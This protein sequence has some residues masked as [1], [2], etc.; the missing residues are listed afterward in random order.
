MALHARLLFALDDSG[1]G[2]GSATEALEASARLLLARIRID[3]VTDINDIQLD[4]ARV[5]VNN[6]VRPFLS[7]AGQ[8]A[9]L[10]RT[11]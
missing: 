7:T 4:P 8:L 5:R 11:S 1:V 6:L 10:A 2:A 9:Y 3:Q